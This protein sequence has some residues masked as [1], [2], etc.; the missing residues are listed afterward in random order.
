M[1]KAG[2]NSSAR[3]P[4]G[5]CRD[6]EKEATEIVKAKIAA[7]ALSLPPNAA[8]I[9]FQIATIARAADVDGLQQ[10][11]NDHIAGKWERYWRSEQERELIK[12]DRATADE[13]RGSGLPELKRLKCLSEEQA[14]LLDHPETMHVLKIALTRM[15]H[16]DD[17][18]RR[19]LLRG[20]DEAAVFREAVAVLCEAS[21]LALTIFQTKKRR[22]RPSGMGWEWEYFSE[23]ML[24]LLQKVRAAGGRLTLDKN[25]NSG[26]LLEAHS[27]LVSVLPADDWPRRPPISWF[28]RV[29]K[30]DRKMPDQDTFARILLS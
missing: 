14:L 30:L 18:E 15:W 4:W 5:K 21:S 20:Y 9:A 13:Y 26:T 2:K 19:G 3:V 1:A 29:K 25:T 28:V 27:L 16:P 17:Y 22:G 12:Q 23:Q 11:I 8:D 7:G 10:Y 6:Y 24:E